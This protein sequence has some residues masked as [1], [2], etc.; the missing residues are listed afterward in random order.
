MQTELHESTERF[1]NLVDSVDGIVWEASLDP[2]QFTFVSRQAKRI[3]GYP[4]F[5]WLDD[6]DFLQ[7][8][9]HKSD[10]DWVLKFFETEHRSL[11]NQKLE[12]LMRSETGETKW[13]RVIATLGGE[14]DRRPKQARGLMI[15][16]SDTKRIHAALWESTE[17]MRL[18]IEHTPTS[19]AMFDH[20]M[21]YVLVSRRWYED[22][23]LVGEN[24]IGRSHYEVVPDIP[25]RWKRI[26]R[27]CLEGNSANCD[28]DAFE[29]AD[30]H[31]DFVRWEI[32]P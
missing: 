13:L 18:F 7:G 10:R 9:L 5:L 31:T 32:H 24:L 19:V 6:E 26:H 23:G 1:R 20:E 11:P 29:H 30:G 25:D 21:R 2:F 22:N 28:E 8:H 14:E 16:I 15:D 27:H 4:A 3:L 17:Q 12:F